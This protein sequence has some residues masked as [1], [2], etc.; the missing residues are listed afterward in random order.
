M[1]WA[2]KPATIE[3]KKL[4]DIDVDESVKIIWQH[5]G[6]VRLSFSLCVC[7]VRT[8]MLM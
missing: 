5:I 8:T 6:D 4:A 7:G 2:E 3:E 1:K